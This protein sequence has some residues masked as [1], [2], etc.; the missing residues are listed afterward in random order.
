MSQHLFSLTYP[1]PTLLTVLSTSPL[2][3]IALALLHFPLVFPKGQSLVLFFL[4]FTL[5]PSAKFFLTVL[6]HFTFM[7]M[8]RSFISLFHLQTP[9][10]IFQ[11]YP[12]PLI[13]STL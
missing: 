3:N 2:E 12:P 4:L 1:P 7:L 13:P 5:H 8:T 6:F 10:V 9:L 11:F